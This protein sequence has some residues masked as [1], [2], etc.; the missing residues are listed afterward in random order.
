MDDLE[1]KMAYRTTDQAFS[2][3]FEILRRV[4]S[5]HPGFKNRGEAPTYYANAFVFKV[6]FVELALVCHCITILILI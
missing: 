2:G 3:A 5:D 4:F 6:Q 1:K